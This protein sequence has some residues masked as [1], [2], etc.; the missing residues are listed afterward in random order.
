MSRY[1]TA[2]A[3]AQKLE[4][5]VKARFGE[6]NPNYGLALGLLGAA[7]Q[8]LGNYAEAEQLLKRVLAIYSRLGSDTMGVAVTLGNLARLYDAQVRYAEADRR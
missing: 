4:A 5:T 8:D 3:E 7:Y 2:L 6:E 1:A